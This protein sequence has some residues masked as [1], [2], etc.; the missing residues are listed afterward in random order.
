MRTFRGIF[1]VLKFFDDDIGFALEHVH[2]RTGL[3]ELRDNLHGR[4]SRSHDGHFLPREVEIPFPL[5]AVEHSPFELFGVFEL[6]NIWLVQETATVDEKPTA[7]N[8]VFRGRNHPL[9][10][11]LA[12]F[13]AL[14]ASL[15]KKF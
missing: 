11:A 10:F 1:S 15:K 14:H 9:I 7:V 12:P 5:G 8:L 6:G 3:G 13:R 2:F 4:A